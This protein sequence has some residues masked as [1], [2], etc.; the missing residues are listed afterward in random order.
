V[1]RPPPAEPSRRTFTKISGYERCPTKAALA[2][3]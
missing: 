2:Q 1:A 3:G